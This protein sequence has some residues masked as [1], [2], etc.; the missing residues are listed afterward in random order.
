M[1]KQTAN[2]QDRLI[3][4]TAIV[5][6][7]AT[8]GKDV[9]IGPYT[10]I[11]PEVV[12]GNGSVIGARV[13][14]EG[15]TTIGCENE[16]FDGAIIGCRTQ[17]LKYNGEDGPVIIGDNNMIREYVTISAGTHPK[18]TTRI[19]NQNLLMANVHVG[20][21]SQIGDQVKIANVTALAGHVEVQDFATIGG[22][23]SIHQSCRIGKFSMIGA[24]SK[25]SQDIPPFMM[26]DGHPVKTYG[27][28]TVGLKRAN[29]TSQDLSLLKKAYKCIYRSRNTPGSAL[30]TL[31]NDFPEDPLVR[32]L[33][34]FLESSSRGISK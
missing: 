11:G 25:I 4:P 14:I 15:N 32:E 23:T 22:L 21:G 9:Q 28:N 8:I 33:I 13:T 29:F 31:K 27:P 26:C 12:I 3:H 5:A 19:G 7:S 6:S 16:I 24:G 20:H 1:L 17:D 34:D 18:E 10:L 30:K 2:L